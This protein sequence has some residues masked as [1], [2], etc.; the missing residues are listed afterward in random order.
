[1]RGIYIKGEARSGKIPTRYPTKVSVI[2]CA[3]CSR[4]W[5]TRGR[6]NLMRARLE[7]RSTRNVPRAVKK[8]S[9]L[10]EERGK[11]HRTTVVT[12]K[13]S[14]LSKDSER[15]I[16]RGYCRGF[17]LWGPSFEYMMSLKPKPRTNSVQKGII[18]VKK[19]NVGK[20]RGQWRS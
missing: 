2:G 8:A 12:S 3:S 17:G 18:G 16:S 11:G 9:F 14:F 4:T 6:K 5:G 19:A 15:R 10:A 20:R 1:M 13:S 7:C